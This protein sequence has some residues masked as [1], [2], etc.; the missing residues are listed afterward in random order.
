VVIGADAR[1]GETHMKNTGKRSH[2][3]NGS[4]VPRELIT[5]TRAADIV[6]VPK[7]RCLAI[8]GMGSPQDPRFRASVEALFS[9][10]Y[11]LKFSRKN[12]GKSDFK[13]G[14]LE[15]HWA[16]D[17]PGTTTSRPAPEDW[18]WRLRI[19]VPEG[20]T[21]DEV[22]RIK[23]EVVSKKGG[24]LQGSGVV[25]HVFVESVPAQRLGRILHIGPYSEEDASFALISAALDRAGLK[26]APTHIEVYRKDPGHTRSAALETVL[27]RE[28]AA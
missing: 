4:P 16:A 28:L 14:P 23:H 13:V 26:P 24:K 9:V 27:L 6:S 17:V 2:A 25:P 22:E 11:T 3:E 21:R 10:A 8:D 19:C 7:R 18:R 15:G 12:G 1:T 5:A 20:V